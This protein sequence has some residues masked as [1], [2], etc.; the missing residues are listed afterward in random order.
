M[1]QANEE[2]TQYAYAVSHDLKTPLRAIRNYAD[3]LREDLEGTLDGD[4]KQY[5]DGVG[6]AAL[7]ADTLGGG[8]LKTSSVNFSCAITVSALNRATRSRY[9]E[10]L[11]GCIPK[12]NMMVRELAFPLLK[13]R[14]KSWVV[15]Y[16]LSQSPGKEALSLS[17]FPK[18]YRRI[19]REQETFCGSNG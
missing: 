4:Q 2:L 5:L 6:R 17:Y 3:F 19:R 9:S 13:R 7:E 14:L 8:F 18:L 11:S 12:K 16:V 1:R 15:R 10:Y